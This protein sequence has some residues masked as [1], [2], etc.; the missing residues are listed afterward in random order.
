M[1]SGGGGATDNDESE[2]LA[3]ACRSSARA[4]VR[5]CLGQRGLGDDAKAP[6]LDQTAVDSILGELEGAPEDFL[7]AAAPLRTF[8]A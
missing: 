8:A 5:L 2:K 1:S 3:R 6:L 4:V 7:N